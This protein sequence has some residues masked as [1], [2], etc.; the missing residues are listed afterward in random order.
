MFLEERKAYV[1]I[2][3]LAPDIASI[4]KKLNLYEESNYFLELALKSCT[5]IG[6]EV[7]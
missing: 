4:Y 6:K 2:E 7:I 5:L 3:A 1:D